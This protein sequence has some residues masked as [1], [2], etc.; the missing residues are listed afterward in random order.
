[1]PIFLAEAAVYVANALFEGSLVA[2]EVI[3][4]GLTVIVTVAANVALTK[5]MQA[6]AG[7]PSGLGTTGPPPSR[8]VTA[9]GTIEFRQLIYGQVRTAGFL[10]Y[11]GTSGANNNLLWFVVV[12]A[13]H[14]V[15]AIDDVWLDSRQILNSDING[16]GQVT[17]ASFNNGGL[18]QLSIFKHFGSATS[19]VDSALNFSIAE[20]DSSHVGYG[21][22]YIVFEMARDDVVWPTGAPS[23][24]FALT[25]GRKLYDPRLDSTNGG[26]GLHRVNDP[27]T[28]AWSQNWALAVRDYLAGGAVV[29]AS[30]TPDKRLALGENDARIDDAFIIAAANHADEVVTIPLPVLPMTLLWT[31][32]TVSITPHGDGLPLYLSSSDSVIGPDGVTYFVDPG[33]GVADNGFGLTVIYSGPTTDNF[34]THYGVG[35]GSSATEARFTADAQLSAGTTHGENLGIL[36]S[37]GNGHICYVGGKYRLYAGVYTV[38][39]VT[40]TQ[41]DIVGPIDVLTHDPADQVWNYVDGT[42]FDEANGWTQGPFPAQQNPA[43]ETDDGRQYPRSIDLQATR[44]N[45]RAQRLAQVVLQ[46]GRNMLTTNPS[47]L[48]QKALQIAQWDTFNLDIPEYSWSGQVFRCVQWKLLASGFVS[49]AARSEGSAAYADLP[50]LGYVDPSTNNPPAFVTN[51]PDAPLGLSVLPVVNGVALFISPPVYFPAS[52]ILEIWEYTS[53]SP[54]SNAIKVGQTTASVF[55][56]THADSLARY[57]WVTTADVNGGRSGS[58][59]SGAGTP[60]AA[61]PSQYWSPQ[62]R[63]NAQVIGGTI[64]KA[65]GSLAWDTDVTSAAP[66]A[67][68]SIEGTYEGIG[69]SSIGLASGIGSVLVP[70]STAGYYGIYPHADSAQ[71]IVFAGATALATLATPTLGDRYRITFDGFTVDYFINNAFVAS[72]PLQGTLLYIGLAMYHPGETFASVGVAASSISTPTQF[73]ATGTCVVNDTNAYK[74]G[75]VGANDSAVYSILGYKNCHIVGKFNAVPTSHT[76][77][78]IMGL[79]QTPAASNAV[80]NADFALVPG[81]NWEAVESGTVAQTFGSMSTADVVAIT[82]DGTS[83]RYYIN[84]FVTPVR[85]VVPGAATTFYAFCPFHD[86]G[87]GINSLRFAASTNLAVQDTPQIAPN[88]TSQVISATAANTSSGSLISVGQDVDLITGSGTFIGTTVSIAFSAMVTVFAEHASLNAPTQIYITRDG[89]QIGT[90]LIDLQ[91][92]TSNVAPTGGPVLFWVLPITLFV[93]DAPSAGAHTYAAHFHAVVGSNSGGTVLLHVETGPMAL[94]VREDKR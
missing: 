62:L 86:P 65:G 80:A 89:T 74:G 41:D 36:L 77:N 23:A 82:W 44:G 83:I 66:Y 6:L 47:A 50:V 8:S 68:V 14:E 81:T 84:D 21:I 30:G 45:Y 90:A 53:N 22:P 12:L 43:Y 75:S 18:P 28:W 16:G 63:G 93:N 13:G 17:A 64:Q 59:P 71:T 5:I 78:C 9:R 7:K 32:G 46:Q 49:I 91:G 56:V 40:L 61:L 42:F 24:F 2:A 94:D 51:P 79:S 4:A 60:G 55:T 54:F 20:W 85:L 57:Y 1:M 39:T 72:V 25:K 38:P 27:S 33:I 73:I 31:N 26:S 35:G 92:Y 69:A 29:Y 48:S 3:Y 10:A 58:F 88:A 87:A 52:Q 37:A 76:G 67:A 15:S 70:Q 19:A 11:Y 34:V